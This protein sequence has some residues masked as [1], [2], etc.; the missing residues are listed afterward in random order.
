MAW[1]GGVRG[2]LERFLGGFLESHALPPRVLKAL[3]HILACRTA[4]LGGHVSACPECGEVTHH[5]N[6]CRDR[7]CP[8]CGAY[9]RARW[10]EARE[11]DLLDVG[12]FHV[13]FTVPPELNGLFLRN[14]AAL[15]S[16][17]FAS[18]WGALKA[19]AADGRLLG[20]VPGAVAVLHTW[21]RKMQYHPH[22]HMVV[23]GGGLDARGRW[24]NA[25]YAGYLVPA[26]ALSKAFR[27]RFLA[28]VRDLARAGRLSYG[29]ACAGLADP[30]EMSRLLSG[31]WR[32]PW[33]VYAKRPF[34]DASCV[35]RYLGR[36]THRV[37]ISDDRVV[38]VEG[39]RVS[40]R[41]RDSRDG[42]RVKTCTLA[43]EEFVRRFCT[44]VLPEGFRRLRHYGVLASRGKLGRLDACRAMTG[45]PPA[46]RREVP[47]E[48]TVARMIGRPPG[49]CARCGR[50]LVV[51]AGIPRQGV[52][53]LC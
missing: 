44:H 12:Y 24:R 1:K 26:R 52:R 34:S 28:G 2:V 49:T 17:L 22:V 13:V 14:Q 27:G 30:A 25:R 35:V 5:Y 15:Y 43:G 47:P 29:G 3:S 7:H 32:R 53:L 19:L 46:A 38:G 50:A 45:T 16:L 40:F 39:G 51:V 31:L 37:A 36:Y 8:R 18:A 10:V 21:G 48:E 4:A 6:S 23:T 20:A 9:A 41:Y 33:V 11:R 42:D